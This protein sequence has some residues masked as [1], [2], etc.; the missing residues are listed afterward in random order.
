MRQDIHI[1]L[2]LRL[3][4]RTLIGVMTVMLLFGVVDELG[5][6]SL[7][8][9]TY[10]PAPSGVYTQM[11]TTN[12]AFL[13]RNGGNV[14]VGTSVLPGGLSA[15]GNVV[16]NGGVVVNQMGTTWGGWNEAVRLSNG[17]NSAITYPSGGMF[18]GM[19]ANRNFYWANTSAG[20]YPMILSATGDLTISGVLHAGCHSVAFGNTGTTSCGAN[21]AA[22]AVNYT[23]NFLSMAGMEAA[24]GSMN[25]PY[26]Q[27]NY[28]NFP[29]GGSMLCCKIQ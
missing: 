6:E 3:T 28:I 27:I 22:I 12:N 26:T 11:I 17:A 25:L 29:T 7:S 15:T 24:S 4:T 18:F 21:E 1:H 23:S 20:T 16:V 14:L 2:D 8:L 13:A 9:S 5:S 10:Y 19:H